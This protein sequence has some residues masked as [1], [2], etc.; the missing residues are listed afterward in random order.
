MD[1]AKIVQIALLGEVPPTLRFL[2]VYV[3]DST[4]SFHAVFTDD[5]PERH[6]ECASVVLTEIL[7]SCPANIKLNEMIIRDSAISWKL[8]GG[9][10]LLYLRYGELSD[11]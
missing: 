4:L 6:I 2:Y 11:T 3:Q 8:N 5:A 10:N 9:Q 7:A 1:I